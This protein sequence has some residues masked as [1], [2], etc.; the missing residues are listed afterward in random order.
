MKTLPYFD[1][2]LEGRRRGD[3]AALAFDRYVHWGFWDD[4]ARADPGGA[5]LAAAMAR[6]DSEVLAAA[7]IRDGQAVLDAGCGFGGTLSGLDALRRGMT[8]VGLNLDPR[9]LAVARQ[10][11][12]PAASNSLTWLR[13]DA[14]ELPFADASFDRVVAV[15]CVFHFPS[16]ARFLKE[17]ARVLKPGGR[18][19]LSDFV[20]VSLAGRGTWLARRLEA[21]VERGYGPSRGWD[22]GTYADMARAAGLAVVADRDVTAHTLPTYPNLRRLLKA[23]GREAAELLLWPT[24]VLEWLSRLGLLRY[25]IVAFGKP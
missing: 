11:L 1:A 7:D 22:E 2:I 16:R 15:E 3:P 23:G 17:A 13:A 12:R 18:L 5:D 4:P 20:P 25:R 6:L 9:Q 8:L 14:C 19:S 21:I 24:R 10:R